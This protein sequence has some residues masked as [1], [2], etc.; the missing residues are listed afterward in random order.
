[1]RKINKPEIKLNQMKH[2]IRKLMICVIALQGC[3]SSDNTK[4]K[5][6]AVSEEAKPESTLIWTYDYSTE[7][8]IKNRAVKASE[9]TP[10]NMV[11]FINSNKGGKEIHLELVKVSHDTIY[12]RIAESTFLTQQ[13]GTTGADEYMSTTIFT[14]TE[15][16]N[17]EFVN[18]DFEIGDHASPGTYS[19]KYFYDRNTQY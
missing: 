3:N 13:M 5:K 2:C 7:M 9:L 17:V 18:F 10:E 1:L 11:A 8:P 12:V 4:N 19:R 16:K 6:V 14:L 15:L